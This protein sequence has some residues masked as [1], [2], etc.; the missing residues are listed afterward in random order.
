MRAPLPREKY[1][2]VFP[3][4]PGPGCGWCDYRRNCPEGQAAT[5]ARQPWDALAP[6]S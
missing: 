2:E 5:V 4:Q 6:L 1:D 3:P